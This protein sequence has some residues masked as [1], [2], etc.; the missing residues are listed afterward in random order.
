[1][2]GIDHVLKAFRLFKKEH[3][4]CNVQLVI[5]G[6][7]S[8]DDPETNYVSNSILNFLRLDTEYPMEIKQD[9][10]IIN[11]P[12]LD[13]ILNVLM[14]KAWMALQLSIREGF[15][16]KVTEALHKHTPIIAYNVGGIPNQIKHGES[17]ILVNVGDYEQVAE[18]LTF[19]WKNPKEYEKMKQC[20]DNPQHYF[21]IANMANWLNLLRQELPQGD[22]T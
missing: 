2:V 16:V 11:I 12:P 13:Q 18:W 9:I 19:F 7:G 6:H 20:S 3:A 5:G 10:V 1:M 14:R 8:V 22:A 15:E 4:N 21:V 17:G